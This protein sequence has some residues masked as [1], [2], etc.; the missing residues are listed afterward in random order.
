MAPLAEKRSLGSAVARAVVGVLLMIALVPGNGAVSTKRAGAAATRSV[1]YRGATFDVPAGW[2]V[3]RL[4]PRSTR[5][6]RFDV[7][8]VYLGRQGRQPDCPAKLI[9]RTDAVQVEPLD[10]AA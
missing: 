7:H 4:G 6:V 10:A 3:Y 8:A 9:G 2:P 1:T 5:C